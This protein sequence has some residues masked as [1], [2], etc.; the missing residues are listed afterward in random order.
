MRLS[1][2]NTDRSATQNNQMIRCFLHLEKGF[3]GQKRDVLQTQYR[4]NCRTRSCRNYNTTRQNIKFPSPHSIGRH[5]AA[6]FSQYR[7]AKPFK[8]VLTVMR[9]DLG[10]Y[11]LDM[12]KAFLVMPM[13]GQW[14][15]ICFKPHLGA[16]RVF[17]G[18]QQGLR[19]NA[20]IIQTIPPHFGT[21]KKDHVN[22]HLN[23]TCRQR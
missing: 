22:P 12:G 18:R 15:I 2:L 13:G 10:N 1:H 23:S 6:K 7:H 19:G 3:I 9:R 17:G 11:L 5:K 20:P 14:R 21:F 16:A 8:A 4:C